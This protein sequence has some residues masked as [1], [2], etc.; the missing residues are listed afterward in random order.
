MTSPGQLM[1]WPSYRNPKREQPLDNIIAKGF[2]ISDVQV[3]S[4]E[5]LSD[6]KMLSCNLRFLD[7]DAARVR[8]G[9]HE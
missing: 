7:V 4:S 2:E 3:K 5:R 1:T 8:R 6:H 9:K